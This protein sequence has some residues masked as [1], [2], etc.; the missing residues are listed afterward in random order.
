MMYAQIAAGA[1]I[2]VF[3]VALLG[4]QRRRRLS[5]QNELKLIGR[6]HHHSV[7]YELVLKTM[8]LA[9]WRLDV[10]S[11]VLAL[12][13]DFRL[14]TDDLGFRSDIHLSELIQRVEPEDR[15]EVERCF[16][17]ISKGIIEDLHVQFRF[18]LPTL[19]SSVWT[20]VYATV[21]ERLPDGGVKS[22]VG[23]IQNIARRK[24]LESELILARNKAEES[25]RLKSAFL[26]NISHEIHT[27][28]NAIVGFS[29]ILPMASSEEERQN[30]VNIIHENNEKLL[31]IFSDIVNLST[32]EANEESKPIA[33]SDV[34]VTALLDKLHQSYVHRS[35][36]A[37]LRILCDQ[38]AGAI[39]ISS[40]EESLTTILGHFLDNALKFTERGIVTL[41][42]KFMGDDMLRLY[43]KDTGPG[44]PVADR[45]RIF[46]R[47]VKLNDFIQGMGLGL[48][49]SRML[50]YR[51][52]A[53]LGV[54]SE[55]GRGSIFWID[56]P[57]G[58]NK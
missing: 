3:L 47:F 17:E 39:T 58:K 22:V 27:P 36:N 10:S 2:I 30:M 52:G 12:D 34:D 15:Q 33:L 48:S 19:D 18:Q 16:N 49:V 23:T 43:V 1:T 25:D 57:L 42:S 8:H 5:L 31:R 6:L 29:D 26:A 38:A 53:S 41:G 56:L 11:E 35:S 46:E 44:I 21:A 32:V 20:E 7:E 24:Q 40:D 9:T 4:Y 28:L 55:E 14:Q 50:A 13:N 54:E 37:N 51:I 45:E